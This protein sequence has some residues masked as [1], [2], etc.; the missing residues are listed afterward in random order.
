MKP[1]DIKLGDWKRILMGEVPPEFFIE[2]L[3]RVVF[4]FLL[5]V[6]SMR[7]L[8]RRMAGQVNRIEMIA[9]FS[10]AAAIGVPL[11]SPDRG[12]LP[13]VIIAVIVVAVGRLVAGISFR[14]QRFESLA[15]DEYDTL[16][17]D[18]V[19]QME[20]MKK[21]RLTMERLYATL[22]KEGIRHLGEVT[23][24]YFE[25]NGDFSLMQADQPKPGLA[26]I[27]AYDKEL[28]GEQALDDVKVCD[29]CGSQQTEQ[30]KN[31]SQCVNCGNENWVNAI[32]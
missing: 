15:E 1:D 14:N 8:G 20:R 19:I 5:L 31:S 3:I 24:L 11:Q 9:L 30:G 23:R 6:I 27:P 26:V 22:R 18:G 4:I 16:I 29:E 10:L 13:A 25:A 7:I 2:L 21:A 28:L 32:Q 12:L 17:R